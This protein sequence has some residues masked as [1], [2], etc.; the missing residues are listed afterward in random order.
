MRKQLLFLGLGILFL[1]SARAQETTSDMVGLVQADKSPLAG[2]TVTAVHTPSGTTYKTTTRSDGRFNLPNLRI[3]G[4]YELTVSYVGYQTEHKDGIILVLGQEFKEDFSMQTDTKTL[5]E[6]TVTSAG[7][8]GKVFN[9]SHT[10]SQEIITRSQLD[11]L[12]TVNRS[13]LDFTRLSPVANG[14]AFGG[15]SSQYNNLTVDGANFNNSFGLS[16]T[17]G[18]QTNSQPISLDA[19]EQIQVNVSPY[20][21][22]QGGFSGAG[23]NSVTRSGTN[24]FSGSLYTYIKGPGT[25]GYKVGDITVPRQDFSYNLTGFR[26]AGPI[27]P[28]KLFFFVS[29]EEENRT[30]PGTSFVASDAT[31]AANGVSVSNANAD[32]LN[33]LAAF[34]KSK[35]GYDPG[36]YENYSYKTQSKKLTIKLDWNLDASNTLTLKYNYL[37]SSRQ[38]QA[39]NSGSVNSSYGRTPGQYAMP[40]FGSGYTIFNNFNIFIAELNTR[41][42]NKASNKLQVGYTALRDSR[43]P[44]T[45]SPF[46]LVDILDG[47]G[48][49]YTSFG[50]EQYTYGNLLN[51]DVFQLN[52]VF[53]FYKGAHE[54]TV[55][56]QDSYKKYQ[57]GFSPSYEGVYRFNSVDAFYAAAA[58]PT[59]T[60]AR[61]DLSYTLP[62][63]SSF[64]LVGPK[65]LELGFFAQDKWRVKDN[66]VLIY[67][68]RVDIPIFQ[69][70]FLYNPAVA[71]LNG[72]YGGVH[73]N[74]GEAPSVNP[75]FGPRVGFNWDVKGDQKT[76]VR[77][78]VGLFAGPPPFVWISNQASNSGVALF[79]SI[80]NSTTT[81]FSPNVNPNPNW[82]ANANGAPSK[83]YSLNVT[84][85]KFRFPQALKSSLAI[86][87]KLP[88][89]WIVTLELTY[90][91]DVNAAFFQNVNLPATGTALAGA[92]PRVRYASSQIY[93][94]G[95]PA[96]A[97]VANPNIGNA[98]YM[99]NVDKG[100]AYTATVQVQKSYKNLNVNVAY[101][102]SVAKDVMVGGS[103]AA[104]MWGSKPISGD[105]NAPQLG[106]SNSY[107]P[108]RIIGSASYRFVY[109]KYFATTVGLL[110]EAAPSGVGSYVYNG[111]LNNDGQTSNDLIYI[112]TQADYTNGKYRVENNGGTDTRTPD[113]V[114]SQI[115]AYIMQDKYLSDHRGGYAERNALVFPWYKRV[116]ANVTQ[117][118]YTKIGK[119]TH[120]IRLSVDI[121]NV[122]NLIDKN[123]GL[124]QLPSA[125][126]GSS[127]LAGG[128]PNVI[129]VG[130]I[131]FDKI[132]PDGQPI[133]SFPYQLAA[134]QTPYT[135][136][137]KDDTSLASRWQ[138]QF[139]IRY[140]FN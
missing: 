113:Q 121:V 89:N 87:Q 38:T 54:I 107:M 23:I 48:N 82:P 16:G 128:V 126:T 105:P 6:V 132:G 27:I 103:T 50:Y 14:L 115:N 62:P 76:Q 94:V 18:G 28:N 111:D 106:Y 140:L 7:N 29:G 85:P 15:Q 25:Q 8:Q 41:L 13:L 123:W 35:Y 139:G 137:F 136:S 88:D 74:T 53:T 122:G 114:W 92:D 99:T 98:I 84:D 110:F 24:T 77:G 67:G 116:D 26:V 138:M 37:N 46:P 57:N 66:F 40:F 90:A 97:T 109:G 104:T 125:G 127:I 10:G 63:G 30:D 71:N 75:L 55:G 33:A 45:S 119:N 120:T 64:P 102:Y 56:T 52:D 133:Y 91:K 59:K 73:L 36:A 96:D 78:G 72:F 65:D 51:T 58:D 101:T 5:N 81:P 1:L 44:L 86:D 129:N 95:G 61:Y 118:F 117:D 83:S 31:H 135:K 60:A 70:T 130:I 3:G 20:D 49:P 134:S 112:P 22:R 93:P 43:T 79:G 131:K 2:A 80:S 11:K 100:Y 17:L 39:S 42:S 124:Y 108:Q 4:P 12:P 19:I 34:L 69:N 21:V 68:I 9:S 47:S 32:T